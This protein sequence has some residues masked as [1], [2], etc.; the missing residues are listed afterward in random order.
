[1]CPRSH[2]LYCDETVI[3]DGHRTLALKLQMSLCLL[4]RLVVIVFIWILD[5]HITSTS[6][7]N[8]EGFDLP[9]LPPELHPPPSYL[10]LYNIS[11]P[12]AGKKIPRNVWIAIRN[13]SD[14]RPGHMRGEGMEN[15]MQKCIALIF[16]FYT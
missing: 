7:T 2:C 11:G 3:V 10:S 15:H 9:L 6:S 14:D 8:I 4:A 12:E 5:D 16:Y 1:M 13:I